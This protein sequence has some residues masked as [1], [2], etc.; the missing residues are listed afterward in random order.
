[1]QLNSAP[2]ES[3]DPTLSLEKEPKL[4]LQRPNFN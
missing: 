3:F 2:P 1:L 4:I